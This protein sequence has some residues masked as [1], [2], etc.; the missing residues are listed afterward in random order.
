VPFSINIVPPTAPLVP[1]GAMD[2]TLKVTRAKDY[3]EPLELFFPALPPGV[4][5]PTSVPV[6]ADKNEVIVTLDVHPSAEVGNWHLIAEAKPA[7][8]MPARRDPLAVGMGMA[9]AARRRNRVVESP[10]PVASEA[11]SL[12]VVEPLVAGQFSPA[13]GEQGK[14]VTV[15]CQLEAVAPI[16]GPLVARLEG[17]PPRATAAPIELK[18]GAKKVEFQV[19]I[20]ATTPPGEHRSLV[21]ALTRSVGG[22]KVVQHVGRGGSLKVE[23]AGAVKTDKAG[24][25]LS[26][27]DA[28]RQEQNKDAAKKP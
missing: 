24:K 26:R 18:A 10:I 15:A 21:C 22:Q 13:W 27:L 4:E 16:T 8:A 23:A 19:K 3:G 17:L 25:P 7:R 12:K 9:V 1:D 28:L 6:P 5:A 20:D 2:I 11:I 14:S